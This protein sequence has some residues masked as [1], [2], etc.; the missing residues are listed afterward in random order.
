MLL[1]PVVGCDY[2]PKKHQDQC[3]W[4]LEEAVDGVKM[5]RK[6]KMHIAMWSGHKWHAELGAAARRQKSL[7]M[8]RADEGLR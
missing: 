7:R 1:Q 5:P 3:T 4:A 8:R 2:C 6:H